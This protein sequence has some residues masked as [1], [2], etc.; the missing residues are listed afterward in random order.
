MMPLTS[1]Q[2]RTAIGTLRLGSRVSSASG[3]AASNPPKASTA[4]LNATRTSLALP[5]GQENDVAA[6]ED[7]DAAERDDV[8]E[9]ADHADRHRHLGADRP[10]DVG[11]EGSGARVDARELG[12]A[13]RGGAHADHGNQE[14][15]RC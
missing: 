4:K 6:D 3:A 11:D 13:A 8:A 7:V 10:G 2:P 1:T 5:P 14:D 12:Q 15:Q 9:H